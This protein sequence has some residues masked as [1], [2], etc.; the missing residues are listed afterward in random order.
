MA[1]VG[2]KAVDRDRHAIHIRNR[3]SSRP[4]PLPPSGSPQRIETR[5]QDRLDNNRMAANRDLEASAPD[6]RSRPTQ[7]RRSTYVNS[8][9]QGS[10]RWHNRYVEVHHIL[11]D[12]ELLVETGRGVVAIIGLNVYHPYSAA[13]CDFSKLLN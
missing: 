13:R 4:P 6:D 9:L 11:A 7:C 2:P 1:A 8:M 12:T 10:T 3:R 5:A